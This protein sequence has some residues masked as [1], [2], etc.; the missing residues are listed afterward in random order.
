ME[1][2]LNKI[3]EPSIRHRRKSTYT[4]KVRLRD[5]NTCQCCGWLGSEVHHINAIRFG[6]EDTPENMI[7]LCN[8]C[9]K[10]APE[11]KLQFEAYKRTGGARKVAI[12]G[13]AVSECLKTN[14]DM[15][16][17]IEMALKIFSSLA[18]M[19]VK[20]QEND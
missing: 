20:N 17:C 7:L 5:N 15:I 19:S 16:S 18:E 3:V 6:G 4:R 9:H 8:M 12:L 2:T 10:Y 1:T 13:I 14:Q 11:N